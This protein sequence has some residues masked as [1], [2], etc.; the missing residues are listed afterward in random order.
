MK[1]ILMLVTILIMTLSSTCNAQNNTD[2]QKFDTLKVKVKII[3][4]FPVGWG[5]KYK[6][7]IEK[8]D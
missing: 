8:I 6:A 7:V 2:N 3:N 1:R 4:M 5:N